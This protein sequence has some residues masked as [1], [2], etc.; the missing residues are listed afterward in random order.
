MRQRWMLFF[1]TALIILFGSCNY[2]HGT[3]YVTNEFDSIRSIAPK[4]THINEVI[5]P[6][7]IIITDN[8][9]IIQNAFYNEQNLFYVYSS[10]SLRFLYS[11]QKRG[12]GPTEIIAPSLIQ[13]TTNN[14][15]AIIDHSSFKILYYKLNN[16]KAELCKEDKLIVNTRQPLQEVYFCNDSILLYSTIDNKIQ[17]YN[18]NSKKIIDSFSFKSNIKA[19]MGNKYNISFDSFHLGYTNGIINV[20]FHYINNLVRG[21]VTSDYTIQIRDSIINIPKPLNED[22]YDNIWYYM[23]VSMTNDYSF[24]QFS[25]YPSRIFQPF[26]INSGERQFKSSLE[27]YTHFGKK[28]CLIP[29]N[30]NVLRCKFD[31]KHKRIFTWNPLEDFDYFI[32]YNL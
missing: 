11:F 3:N 9:V 26:P 4:K 25:G 15:I 13:N 32:T 30:E 10:D 6:E 2:N 8:Y 1:P 31:E 12:T 14:T 7:D 29:I 18:L 28:I 21:T 23:Y 5:Q 19:L 27:V 20:G 22:I 24:A 16:K 17:T